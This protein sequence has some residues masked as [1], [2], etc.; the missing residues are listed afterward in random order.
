[1]SAIAVVL[2]TNVLVSALAYPDSVPGRIL[3]AWRAGSVDLIL[4]T[5]ILEEL[6]RVLPRLQHRHGLGAAEID[7]LVDSL[8]FQVEAVEPQEGESPQLRDVQD[9]PVLGTLLRAR[10]S[11]PEALLVTGDKDLLALAHL[12]PICT[13]AAFW[14]RH[15][16]L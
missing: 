6:R 12:H 7:E 4:S 5:Y 1:M 8:G 9:Q 16:G 15:G 13:P 2:D 14:A 10:E 3:A 11:W